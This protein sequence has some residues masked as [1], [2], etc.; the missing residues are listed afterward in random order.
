MKKL[1]YV[2]LFLAIFFVFSQDVFAEEVSDEGILQQ[3]LTS[4]DDSNYNFKCLSFGIGTAR[5]D[6]SKSEYI[7][8]YGVLNYVPGTWLDFGSVYT[9]DVDVGPPTTYPSYAFFVGTGGFEKDSYGN[10][11][12]NY[13]LVKKSSYKLVYT[14]FLNRS[15]DFTDFSL[16][17]D[18]ED[19][20]FLYHA[21]AITLDS[22]DILY[23]DDVFSK[24]YVN[25]SINEETRGITIE[26]SFVPKDH[27]VEFGFYVGND[28]FE[29]VDI[30]Q[31]NFI[32][33]Y[34]KE[35]EPIQ[36]TNLQ[37]YKTSE[38]DDSGTNI[39]D[40]DKV[41]SKDEGIFSQLKQCETL[42]IGC[43]V[44]NI[45]TMI[46]NVFVRIGNFFVSILEFF[47]NF[48]IDL[49]NF[50]I[51]F[52]VPEP[53]FISS[54]FNAF[55][56]FLSDKLGLLTFPFDFISHVLNRF[57]NIPDTPV[58]NITV[59]TVSIGNFGTLI[60]GFTFNI[61]E[62]WEKAP[63]NQIYNIYLIFVHCFIVF[64][65]YRLCVKKFNEIVGGCSM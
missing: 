27:F 49:G 41:T 36:L 32:T 12:L 10:S 42:D 24:F 55:S 45:L 17:F 29:D 54:R 51:R 48:F 28:N 61:A 59:P 19:P 30:L 26:F 3:C 6:S 44:D 38:F 39:I 53:D 5:Y 63:F 8:E 16:N 50:L 21:K 58:K 25:T 43:H 15:V 23:D 65:L 1:F 22:N 4:S 13:K 40:I 14:F 18:E 62:Y 11:L 57:L 37:L 35:K 2:W 31:T 33:N 20:N 56:K 52:F 7:S 64:C 47:A 60:P 34:S 46:K 9:F